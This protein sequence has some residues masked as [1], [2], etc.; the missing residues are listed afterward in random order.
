MTSMEDELNV[1]KL[2]LM[3][4]RQIRMKHFDANSAHSF[5]LA[6]VLSASVRDL[7]L[8]YFQFKGDL[9]V[10]LISRLGWNINS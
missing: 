5:S 2:T 8:Y 9:L 10:D 7:I 4:V 3:K 1:W 6:T